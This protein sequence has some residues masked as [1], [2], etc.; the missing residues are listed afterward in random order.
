MGII[1]IDT[2]PFLMQLIQQK[3]NLDLNNLFMDE[4]YS[5]DGSKILWDKIVTLNS[6]SETTEA[7]NKTSS[8]E[9]CG[10]INRNLTIIKKNH[11]IF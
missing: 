11:E 4:F 3:L 9:I 7:E 1:L 6:G 10:W 5:A 2:K 8:Q